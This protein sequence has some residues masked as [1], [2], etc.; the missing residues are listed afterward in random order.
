MTTRE[1]LLWCAFGLYAIAAAAVDW[2]RFERDLKR[3]QRRH[4]AE[5]AAIR[6]GAS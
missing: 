5:L 6:R 2:Y 1:R 3:E 4:A